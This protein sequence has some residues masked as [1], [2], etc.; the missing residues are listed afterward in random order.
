M[1]DAYGLS[2]VCPN[3]TTNQCIS[4]SVQSHFKLKWHMED[5]RPGMLNGPG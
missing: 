4:A 2:P 1:K 3:S 5:A